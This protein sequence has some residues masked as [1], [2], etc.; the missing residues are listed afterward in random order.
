MMHPTP[1]ISA[2]KRGIRSH[3]VA[4]GVILAVVAAAYSN[5]LEVPFHFDDVANIV[6]NPAIKD[7]GYFARPSAA[8]P[9]TSPGQHAN[10]F[11]RYVGGLT[12]ALNY[13]IGGLD[14][15]GYHAVNM[16]IH[17]ATGLAVYALVLVL[18][19][20]PIL[21]SSSLTG[22]A[23]TIA[24]LTALVFV[25]HPIQTQAVTYIVQ[26]FASLVAFWY[27]FSIVA[28]G[29]AR[30]SVRPAVRAGAFIMALVFAVLAMK[31]K[32][33]A[34]TLPFAIALFEVLFFDGPVRRRAA[35]VMAFA[36]LL[37]V[38]PLDYLRR[39][40]ANAAPGRPVVQGV[41]AFS[42]TAASLL[43]SE[44][45]FTQF[46]VVVTYIRLLFVPVGQNLDYD[47][48]RYDSLFA[49]PVFLSLLFLAAI[50][51]LAF[52]LILRSRKTE[53]ALRVISFGILWFFLTSTVESSVIRLP[54]V[55]FEHRVYLPSV[56]A[57][58]AL[59]I[60]VFL[61]GSFAGRRWPRARAAA[62]IALSVAA[63]V[64]AGA[65]WARNRVW[66]DPVHLW[67]DAAA[68]SP[69]KAR[70]HN[71]LATAYLEDGRF[72]EAL[73]EFRA[74]LA[75]EPGHLEA[76]LGM[77]KTL[78]AL[79]RFEEAEGHFETVRQLGPQ[80]PDVY[81]EQG[82]AYIRAG[83]SAEAMQQ[84]RTAVRVSPNHAG[85]R[86][87][88]GLALFRAGALGEAVEHLRAALSIDPGVGPIH[89]LLGQVYE[90]SGSTEEAIG[91]YRA[92]LDREASDAEAHYRLG[93]LL[94]RT[95]D[96][97][98]GIAHLESAVRLAPGDARGHHDLGVAYYL[99]GRNAEAIESLRRSL[100]LQPTNAEAHYTLSLAFE[101]AGDAEL[102][103]EHLRL[104]RALDPS[105][106]QR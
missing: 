74:A 17:V 42:E 5:T 51:W 93:S 26:R 57:L 63:V 87:N 105:I 86:F 77:G 94:G 8:R 103:R 58:T 97:A 85:A 25:A 28:Y 75:I 46:R 3:L 47:Y 62:P 56:G 11:G 90:A 71:N 45:L 27:V 53:P 1:E 41:N 14:V 7:L 79:G 100:E 69:A 72:E 82:N 98:Q 66:A 68:K 55:I 4:V 22:R 89:V 52:Y 38:I 84:Y 12:L 2:R 23:R 18:F 24:L 106:G 83:R 96:L 20:T 92:A 73:A 99:T 49:P 10:T 101:R 64:L 35:R 76:H 36:P 19:A 16:G 34:F 44:Y 104:A 59:V 70:P 21:R 88:L 65:T 80:G 40:A 50:V 102:A 48:P 60:A 29:V 6:D 33:N 95:G 13:R 31:T 39:G 30:L 15:R 54:N 9:I 91:Q 32:E 37:L 43:S 78:A 81:I 67:E 61:G